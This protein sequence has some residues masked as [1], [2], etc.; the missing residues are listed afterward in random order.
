VALGSGAAGLMD[1]A[2][3]AMVVPLSDLR[4]GGK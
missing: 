2:A 3:F 4:C 1:L